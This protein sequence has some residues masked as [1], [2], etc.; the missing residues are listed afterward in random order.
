MYNGIGL[1]TVRGSGT[2]GYVTRN[3][4]HVS[5][6]RSAQMKE[7]SK[8]AGQRGFGGGAPMPK[9]ANADILQHNRKR[10]V[11]VKCLGLQEALEEQGVEAEEVA[12]RVAELRESLLSKLPPAGAGSSGAAGSGRTGET[13]ADAASKER[14]SAAL[15]DALGIATGYVGGSAFDRELQDKQKQER[16]DKRGAEESERAALMAVLEREQ[17]REE[18]QAVKDARRA[19]KDERKAEKKKQ[20]RSRKHSPSRSD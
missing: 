11:E 20:K 6:T 19:E 14:E 8:D 17:A 15:K 7:K 12:R 16:A 1:T 18:R 4:S 2:S 5:A 3:L 9:R 10:E 13:H